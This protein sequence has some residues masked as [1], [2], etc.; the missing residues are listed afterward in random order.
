MTI[1]PTDVDP[2]DPG[3]PENPMPAPSLG[4][5]AGLVSDPFD[6]S[7]DDEVQVPE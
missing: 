1:T 2:G 6:Y 5:S 4:W 3:S 7:R